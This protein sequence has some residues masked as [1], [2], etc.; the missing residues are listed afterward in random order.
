MSSYYPIQD[1]GP[2]MKGMVIG[3]LGIFHVFLAQMAIGG[4]MLLCYFEWLRRTG[5]S[6]NAARFINGYFQ[7]LVLVSFVLGAMTGVAMWFASIQVSPRTIGVLVDEFH[8]LW[9]TEWTFFCTEV[10]SGYAFLR[11]RDRL[12][13]RGRITLLAFYSL[14][15]WFSLFWINGILSFQLT[16]ASWV[17]THSIW[18]GFFN[19][20]FWP[21][22]LYR[23][24][25]AMAIAALA[26]CVVINL[27]NEL[28]RE[29][30]RE[31]IGHASVFLAPMVLMPVLGGWFLASMPADSRSWV[32]GGSVTMTMFMGI[33]VG[34]SLLIGAYALGAFWYLKLNINGFT[35][36]LLCALALAATAGGE[37]VREGVRKP[38]SISQVLYSNSVRPDE[39]ERLRKVGSV[40]KDPYPLRDGLK[41]PND[42]LKTGARVFRFQCSVCHTYDGAN[43]LLDLTGTWTLDQKRMNIAELQRTKP[44]MPPFAGPATEVEALVQLLNWRRAGM[45]H[46][47][48]VSDDPATLKKIQAW[49]DE[50]GTRPGI[51]FIAR[52]DLAAADRSSSDEADATAKER[53]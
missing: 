29:A 38:F 7:A 30:R 28:E 19:P 3:G 24:V 16:P 25:A 1:Y 2:L 8:W 44:F 48:P 6:R 50:V 37:F 13:A 20:S 10:V 11:Y 35:A 40:T 43:G 47:W 15:A 31:L 49:L 5:R 9:A 36:A 23:T 21:S 39:I 51:E 34:G 18:A 33:G 42:Q 26:A 46:T 32:L 45:P 22:L 17:L 14:A 4:G 12:S 27:A 41:Y 53:H 52:K